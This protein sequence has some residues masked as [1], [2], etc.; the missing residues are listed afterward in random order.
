MV[1]SKLSENKLL[2]GTINY[3]F[4]N[5]KLLNL[6]LTH[7]S[8]NG[9]VQKTADN[10]NERL[11]FLGDSILEHIISIYLFRILPQEAEGR[12]SKLKA[13]IV[14]EESLAKAA[15]KMHLGKYLLMGNGEVKNGG[16]E[17]ASIL[18]DSFEA[19]LAAIY[20][21]GGFEDAQRTALKLLEQNIEESIN[22][23]TDH[24]YK[25]ALQEQV[26]ICGANTLS[27]RL[28]LDEGP[29]HNRRFGIQLFLNEELIGE[30]LGK[31]KKEAQQKAAQQGIES[32]KKM[33]NNIEKNGEGK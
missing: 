17:R 1:N 5:Q 30:G 4:K 24:D 22:A 31:S 10:N 13:S 27:Y 19:L 11:E 20:L 26:Q 7:M 6:A 33:A 16:R 29:A 15:S 12:L 23:V 3:Q 21:D 25:T 2:E 18:A 8:F 14:C 9:T 28:N 32:L